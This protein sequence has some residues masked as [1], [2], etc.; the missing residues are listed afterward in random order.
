VPTP[1]QTKKA[2][3]C[4]ER[5]QSLSVPTG[6][7]DTSALDSF[8]VSAAVVQSA[9]DLGA[10]RTV[11]TTLPSG[12]A[13][14]KTY[15]SAVGSVQVEKDTGAGVAFTITQ[16]TPDEL[17]ALRARARAMTIRP[18]TLKSLWIRRFH[19]SVNLREV[20]SL[21]EECGLPMKKVVDMAFVGNGVLELV[22]DAEAFDSIYTTLK[23]T[24]EFDVMDA[25]DP[26]KTRDANA[27]S[28]V[29]DRVAAS[30]AKFY[31]RAIFFAERRRFKALVH[32][33]WRNILSHG[34]AFEKAVQT[35]LSILRTQGPAGTSTTTN[36]VNEGSTRVVPTSLL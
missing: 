4:Q 29:K 11:E 21:F 1:T 14:R 32:Y 9:R 22:C 36:A 34:V 12:V 33:R 28:H 27:P 31:A 26:S 3:R 2:K 17:T 5:V 13:V 23:T 18:I 19:S 8:P 35:S 30:A 24:L 20:R 7:Q 10:G 16:M 25:F 15:A 6:T